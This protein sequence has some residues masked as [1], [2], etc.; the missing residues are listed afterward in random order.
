[1]K[2]LNKE[3]TFDGS[4]FRL[5][6][7]VIGEIEIKHKFKDSYDKSFL[8]KRKEVCLGRIISGVV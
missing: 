3:I 7:E 4:K 1:M 5:N 6:D 8:D 2:S